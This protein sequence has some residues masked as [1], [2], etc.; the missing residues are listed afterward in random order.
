VWDV[1]DGLRP[2]NA[3]VVAA[4]AAARSLEDR[5]RLASLARLQAELLAEQG[6]FEAAVELLREADTQQQAENERANAERHAM[7]AARYQSERQL[8]EIALLREREN[9]QRALMSEQRATQ[10]AEIGR[11]RNWAL[12]LSFAVLGLV[13]LIGLVWRHAR[14]RQRQALRLEAGNTALSAALADAERQRSQADAV[15]ALNRRLLHLA[16]EEMRSPLLTLRSGA[17]RLLVEGGDVQTRQRRIATLAEAAGEL[18]RVAEQMQESA[19]LDPQ[20]SVSLQ[21]NVALDRLLRG[22]VEQLQARAQARARGIVLRRSTPATVRADPARLNLALQEL[23]ELLLNPAPAGSEVEVD[24]C[25]NADHAEIRI[26]DPGARLPESE[27][28]LRREGASIERGRL[29][30]AWA[31]EVLLS[32]GGDVRIAPD[33][34]TGRMLLLRLPLA[35]SAEP[36]R[37]PETDP[38]PTQD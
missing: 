29:G 7:L 6:Q 9:A 37:E 33:A 10:Q 2:S 1:D 31:R 18:M 35:P 20:A 14:E 3:A 12:A 19:A 36:E 5:G 26:G 21:S 34:R 24:L 13:L 27:D 8:R 23:V 38:E 22:L 16:G 30:F 25:C 4:R 32:L 28:I 17:E 11:Q 15:A